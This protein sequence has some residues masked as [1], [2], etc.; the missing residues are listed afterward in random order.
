MSID[1]FDE[2]YIEDDEIHNK[3]LNFPKKKYQCYLNNN[4][5]GSQRTNYNEKRV[6]F[7]TIEIIRVEKYKIYNKISKKNKTEKTEKKEKKENSNCMII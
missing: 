2:I 3:P 1:K 4:S 5:F 6:T 7:S